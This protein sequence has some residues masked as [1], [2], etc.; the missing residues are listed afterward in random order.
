MQ[1]LNL[2][3]SLKTVWY[4]P[5]VVAKQLSHVC[6][7]SSAYTMQSKG[8]ATLNIRSLPATSSRTNNP[9]PAPGMVESPTLRGSWHLTL[10]GVWTFCWF[11]AIGLDESVEE[12]VMTWGYWDP[13]REIWA[14]ENTGEDLQFLV[15]SECWTSQNPV[16][17]D[18][19][20]RQEP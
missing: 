14:W 6:S 19:S 11:W 3:S 18:V 13:A 5:V 1:G 17:M 10:N 4:V 16:V 2:S 8:L 9:R 7:R 15:P 20:A 12:A